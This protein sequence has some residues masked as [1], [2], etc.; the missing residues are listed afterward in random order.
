MSWAGSTSTIGAD[1]AT[2]AAT[3]LPGPGTANTKGSYVELSASTGV[4]AWAFTIQVAYQTSNTL[5]DQYL[6]DIA[7]GA[8][9]SESVIYANMAVEAGQ[10]RG[11]FG[12]PFV[13]LAIATGTRV[14]ARVQN[15]SA[16]TTSVIGL[17][18]VLC[19]EDSVSG[20]TS[21]QTYG[22]DTSDSGGASVDPG[23]SANTK[24]SYTEITASSS[25]D[26]NFL[27]LDVSPPDNAVL[28][29]A[30]WLIDVATGASMSESVIVANLTLS[31]SAST[32]TLFGYPISFFTPDVA[33]GTRIAVRSQCSITD[34]ADRIFDVVLHGLNVPVP[35]GSGGGGS[36]VFFGVGG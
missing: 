32:D 22:A 27:V 36:F 5:N 8:S 19:Q 3:A 26:L 15:S 20:A 12:C 33:S 30:S 35:S 29:S 13:P 1:T 10:V 24:G 7:T 14:S 2:S 11:T 9:M 23:G 25:A 28:T 6:I 31:T 18:L 16:A 21:S 34:A 4:T 17:S